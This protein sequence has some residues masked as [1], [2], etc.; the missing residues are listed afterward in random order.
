MCHHLVLKLISAVNNL[1]T[2][3][4]EKI[5]PLIMYGANGYLTCLNNEEDEHYFIRV[6]P[7][8]FLF[9]DG[10]YLAKCKTAISLQVWAKWAMEHYS[11]W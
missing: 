9:R 2:D 4:D 6:F 5:K 7:T 10:R 1:A 11:H 8:L 3:N